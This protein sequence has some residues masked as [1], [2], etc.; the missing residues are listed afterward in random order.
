M[1]GSGGCGGEGAERSRG[2]LAWG[3]DKGVRG[4][5]GETGQPNK[6]RP[7]PP[8]TYT[9]IHTRPST[10]PHLD[11]LDV[12]GHLVSHQLLCSCVRVCVYGAAEVF[13][14]VWDTSQHIRNKR[15]E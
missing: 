11:R 9:H 1:E 10:P 6:R 12:G 7:Q 3:A 8:P 13:R 15:W 2:G 14:F 4:E 5:S